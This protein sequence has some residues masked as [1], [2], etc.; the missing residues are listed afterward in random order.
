MP[1]GEKALLNDTDTMTNELKQGPKIITPIEGFNA[2]VLIPDDVLA[3]IGVPTFF[4]GGTDDPI[5]VAASLSRF[6]GA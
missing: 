2:S 5:H 3:S 1:V 4:L 6:F